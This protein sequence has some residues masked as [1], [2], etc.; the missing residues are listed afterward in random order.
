MTLILIYVVKII[1]L[2]NFQ[3]VLAVAR[4]LLKSLKNKVSF[5]QNKTKIFCFK[6]I[7]YD[8]PRKETPIPPPPFLGDARNDSSEIFLYGQQKWMQKNRNQRTS[9]NKP[10]LE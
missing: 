3:Q 9:M 10:A 6:N 2:N 1:T 7:F 5:L 8:F 4:Y